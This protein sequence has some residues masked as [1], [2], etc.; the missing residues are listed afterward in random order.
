MDE[1]KLSNHRFDFSIEVIS[2]DKESR[3]AT[4]RIIPDPR[5][6]EWQEIDGKK[7]LLDK[8]ERALL[9]EKFLEDVLNQLPKLPYYDEPPL[10]KSAAEYVEGRVSE[11]RKELAGEFPRP[12][13]ADKSE[14]FLETLKVNAL[15]FAIVSIDVVNSTILSTSLSSKQY[16]LLIE[17]FLYELSNLIPLFRGHVLKYTGDGLIAYFA[18]PGFTAKNDLAIDCA[19]SLRRIVYFGLNPCL[20]ECN[21]PNID[22]RIGLDSGQAFIQTIGSPNTKQHKDIIGSVVNIATKI[23][24]L[25][26]PGGVSLGH[27]TIQ[28]LHTQWR[29]RCAESTLPETWPYKTLDGKPYRIHHVVDFGTA[30]L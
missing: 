24:S 13:F 14:E 9:P 29:V 23:Q 15:G 28:R 12:S 16:A 2:V 26:K 5:R 1:D 22:V 21:F 3:T 6:Y 27:A 19:L 11:I 25:A 17:V 8:F 20:K 18:E 10:I 4:V 7:F 30:E